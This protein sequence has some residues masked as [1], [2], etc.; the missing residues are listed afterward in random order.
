MALPPPADV[1]SARMQRTP[2]QKQQLEKVV[3]L[4]ATT[5]SI[6]LLSRR[7][8]ESGHDMVESP[9]GRSAGPEQRVSVS[10]RGR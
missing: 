10:K 5:Q 9:S 1:F 8:V 3:A 7:G 6:L 2:I 4:L